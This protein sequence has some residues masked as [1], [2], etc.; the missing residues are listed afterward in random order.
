MVYAVDI[1]REPR[2]FHGSNNPE[3]TLLESF[4]EST[5]TREKVDCGGLPALASPRLFHT[6]SGCVVQEPLL[7]SDLTLGFLIRAVRPQIN[8]ST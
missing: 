5:A 6:P 7:S 4:R 3:S 8:H 2:Q 1:R